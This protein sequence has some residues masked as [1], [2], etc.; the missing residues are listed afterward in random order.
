MY[1]R[2]ATAISKLLKMP[3]HAIPSGIFRSLEWRFLKFANCSGVFQSLQKLQWHFS[4]FGNCSGIFMNR[5]N[6]SGIYLICFWDG[7]RVSTRLCGALW[8]VWTAFSFMFT[9]DQPSSFFSFW[10]L[11]AQFFCDLPSKSLCQACWAANLSRRGELHSAVRENGLSVMRN[12][13]YIFKTHQTGNEFQMSFF[14][15]SRF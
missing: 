1:P 3:F 7:S 12:G 8:R 11:L 2:N 14:F 6:W 5:H 4:K 10:K 15:I 9:T 13:M